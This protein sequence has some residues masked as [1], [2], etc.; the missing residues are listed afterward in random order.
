MEAVE[1]TQTAQSAEDW[2]NVAGLWKQ[3]IELMKS[4]PE[5]NENYSTAQQKAKDYGANLEYAQQNAEN[6]KQAVLARG[7]ESF[8]NLNCVFQVQGTMTDLPTVRTIID[9]ND[10]AQLSKEDQISLALYTQSRIRE[11]REFPEKYTNIPTSAPAYEQIVESTRNVCDDCWV[12]ITGER[13]EEGVF[14]IDKIVL[15]GD[16]PWD[17]NDPCCR[18]ISASEFGL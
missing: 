14:T 17:E 15:Q 18:G 8:K 1:V 6:I 10:W 9:K 3:A 2:E 16:T 7:E 11:V 4:V 12:I 13:K 5:S